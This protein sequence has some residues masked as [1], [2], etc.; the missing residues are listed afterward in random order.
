MELTKKE[1]NEEVDA[2]LRGARENIDGAR[3]H[4]RERVYDPEDMENLIQSLLDAEGALSVA[5][6]L[7]TVMVA[8]RLGRASE[9]R[10]RRYD[11][12]R[13]ELRGLLKRAAKSAKDI[14][15]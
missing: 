2:Y 5:D 8:A 15:W 12:I 6:T 14:E 7:M 13:K 9:A 4:L 10:Q 11:S 3:M 1:L